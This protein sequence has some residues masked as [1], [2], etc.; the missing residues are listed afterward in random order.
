MCRN[1]YTIFLHPFLEHCVLNPTR[2]FQQ[3]RVQIT[4]KRLKKYGSMNIKSVICIRHRDEINL[5]QIQ[6]RFT[7]E[8]VGRRKPKARGLAT[9]FYLFLNL[10]FI[11]FHLPL[12]ELK[13]KQV[14]YFQ[15]VHQTRCEC[16]LHSHQICWAR[17]RLC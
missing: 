9:F 16:E 15:A 1:A 12:S 2:I 4:R 8:N 14:N 3:I 7:Y 5:F 17:E 6:T 10:Y 11:I 13:Y